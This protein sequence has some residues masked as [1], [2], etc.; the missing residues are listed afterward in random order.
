MKTYFKLY[1]GENVDFKVQRT[2]YA[3]FSTTYNFEFA[4]KWL[5]CNVVYIIYV[6]HD[7]DYFYLLDQTQF[8]VTL[9]QGILEYIKKY[10]VILDE[11]KKLI[12][13]YNFKPIDKDYAKE[14]LPEK[15]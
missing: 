15:C 3:P 9:Q 5:D 12:V 7:C 2:Y 6:P 10:Y 8:E 1:R 4:F 11:I 14:H 13:E